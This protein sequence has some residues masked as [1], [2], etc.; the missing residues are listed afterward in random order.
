ME[1]TKEEKKAKE[2]IKDYARIL[3]QQIPQNT[4]LKEA[5]KQCALIAVDEILL[6]AGIEWAKPNPAEEKTINSWKAV[7][8]AINKL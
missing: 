7:R 1:E 2:L 4:I 3:H 5:S 6:V 8:K